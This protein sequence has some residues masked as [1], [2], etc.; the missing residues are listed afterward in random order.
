MARARPMRSSVAARILRGGL[1][2]GAGRTISP[3]LVAALAATASPTREA[4]VALGKL[5]D[6]ARRAGAA[7]AADDRLVDGAG[8]PHRAVADAPAATTRLDRRRDRRRTAGV[9]P[10]GLDR[11][12]RQQPA[13][14]RDRGGARRADP[15]QPRPRGRLAAA[16][17]ALQHPSA[18]PRAA[19][20]EGARRR[21]G[22]GDPR[23]DA[24]RASRRPAGRR[25]QGAS[26]SPRSPRSARATD[27]QVKSLL[28][29]FARH[30]RHRSRS[31]ARPPTAALAAIDNRLRLIGARRQP[32]PGHQPRQRAAARRDRPRDHLRRDGRHQH[33][34]WRDDHARRLYRPMSCSSCSAHSCRRAGST[35]ISSSRCRSRSSS[36]AL[37][38]IAARAQRHPLP[39]RPAARDAAGD[40]GRQPGAAAGGALDL[41][42]AEQ[43]VVEPGA[44]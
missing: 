17:D 19:A 7:G 8:R 37:V 18:E 23:G 32:V 26:G 12:T 20:R 44:G 24:A 6:A 40:L 38:G 42:L 33:G 14:R 27:P 16:Q 1:R 13:A 35:P 15:V 43:E 29:Q 5:G 31:C 3:T 36:P 21:A 4:I 41:R 9:A 11:I 2:A 25:Q 34:A 30:A 39:L 28:D 22:P 10:D